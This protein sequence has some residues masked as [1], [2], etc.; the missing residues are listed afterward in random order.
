MILRVYFFQIPVTPNQLAA[1]LVLREVDEN[2]RIR[3]RD[4]HVFNSLTE[5]CRF[6]G[7]REQ[8]ERHSTAYYDQLNDEKRFA[9]S[10]NFIITRKTSSTIVGSV[11][12]EADCDDR[13]A[14]HLHNFSVDEAKRRQGIGKFLL[15]HALRFARERFRFVRL[16]TLDR[17]GKDAQI[18]QG[19]KMYEAAGFVLHNESELKFGEETTDF[20]VFWYELD[21]QK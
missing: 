15:S 13:S 17:H 4:F 14:C 12:I 3:V 7:E 11:G 6:P 18:S 5:V 10:H 20:H 21:F 2:D 8:H 9:E 16:T 19:R 1:G